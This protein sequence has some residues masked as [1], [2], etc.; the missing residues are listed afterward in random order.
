MWCHTITLPLF[1]FTEDAGYEVKI[2]QKLGR[3]IAS[4]FRA[5]ARAFD[6]RDV[7]ALGGLA[8]LGRG[9]YIRWGEWLALSVCG[10]LLIAIAL[11]FG[12]KPEKPG[13]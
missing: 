10:A 3:G 2:F 6:M 11:F 12:S 1:L 9:L 13:K 7:F 8:M 4:P 5:L